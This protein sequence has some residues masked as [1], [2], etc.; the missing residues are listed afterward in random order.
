MKRA[1][2]NLNQA[3]QHIL[4]ELRVNWRTAILL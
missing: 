4:F 3:M 1:I 2:L